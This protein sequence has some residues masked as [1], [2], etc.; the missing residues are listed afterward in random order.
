[1]VQSP[2]RTQLALTK[3]QGMSIPQIVSRDE[4]LIKRLELLAQEE[5]AEK[6]RE[7]INDERRKLPMVEI[8]K[9][10]TFEG[11]HGQ[12][13]LR[14]LFEGRRQLILY[15][16]MFDPDWDE[17]CRYCSYL[18]D[19]IG[20][21][22]HMHAR[23]TTLSLV[24]RAP[25]AKIEPFKARMGWTFP[26]VS[27]F[28]SDFNYDFHATLD[29]AVAPVSYMYRDKAT[30]EAEG[31]PYF[32]SGEQ[33]ATSVF[34][35]E[36]DRVFHTYSSYGSENDLL[37]GIDMYLDLTPLGRQF[38]DEVLRHHDKYDFETAGVAGSASCH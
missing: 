2:A 31:M 22:A 13:S 6:Q 9:S 24:S 18:V 8:T 7:Q 16:F 26:W 30:L 12:L 3:E 33:G 11:P 38:S 29:E 1:M 4:W 23:D 27:S 34:L 37:H 19:N 35:R 36:G 14:D 32:T 25:M 28:G 20:N 5:E 21:L 15:N 10:Y 17:G